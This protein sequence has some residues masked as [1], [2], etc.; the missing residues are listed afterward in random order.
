MDL[1]MPIYF[2]TIAPVNFVSQEEYTASIPPKVDSWEPEPGDLLFTYIKGAFII[3]VNTFWGYRIDEHR[4]MNYFT[5]SAKRRCYASEPMQIHLCKYLNYFEKYYDP[6]KELF[7]IYAKMKYMMDFVPNYNNEAFISD[8]QLY[9][10]SD[11]LLYKVE[12]MDYDNY[13]LH[14][15]YKN[16]DSSICYSDKHAK[17]LMQI[18][19][20]IN[21]IIPLMCH[22]MDNKNMISDNNFILSIYDIVLNKFDQ[23]DIVS[24]LY[25]TAITNVNKSYN[26]DTNLWNKQDIR[27]KNVTTHSLECRE[28]ILLNVLPKYEYTKNVINYN[29]TSIDYSNKFQVTGIT[30]EFAFIALSS[31]TRDED[32]NSEFDKFEALQIRQDESLYIQ[33]KVNSAQTMKCIEIMYGP[34]DE[35][36][37]NYY[38][39]RVFVN[40]NIHPFQR[41]LIFNLF[42]KFFGDPN[43]IKNINLDDYVKMVISAKRMLLNAGM[44]VLPYIVSA[45]LVKFVKKKSINKKE[46]DRI[47]NSEQVKEIENKYKNEDIVKDLFSVLA[48]ILASTFRIIEPS[49]PEIDGVIIE[50]LAP[51]IIEEFK[52]YVLMI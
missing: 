19:I 2:E 39:E 27:S 52:N 33:N 20:I 15:T 34:F 21:M 23:V 41:D 7:S 50:D 11:T 28:N 49:I 29:F 24:K 43:A 51:I 26:S 5:L 18:S 36:E 45:S 48:S 47:M 30:W 3:P 46:L 37:V 42:Y 31:S 38:A 32:N 6:D 14:L 22:Y 17:M 44:R 8:I 9:I 16:K 25:E 12:Q 1:K 13:M 10:L 4:E 40:G 35:E